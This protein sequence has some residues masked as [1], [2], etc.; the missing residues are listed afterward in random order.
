[1]G[2]VIL[3]LR[4]VVGCVFLGAGALKVGHGA[5][6]ASELAAMRV[7]PASLVAPLA[8]FLPFF[9]IGLGAYLI[10]GLYTRA[11]AIVAAVQLA[12]F[13]GVIASVVLRHLPVSCGCF[14][15]ADTAVAS[16]G[17]I[18]RDLALG[19]AAVVVAWRAPGFAAL[20]LRL[21]GPNSVNQKGS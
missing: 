2:V 9:E 3:V 1:M 20:D 14:G 18:V 12:I 15:P 10:V 8:L 11:A 16:W 13:A 17:D 19:A 5:L 21:G 4:L 7:L 6:F